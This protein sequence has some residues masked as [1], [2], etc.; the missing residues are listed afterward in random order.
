MQDRYVGD[1][2]DFAK[3]GLLRRLIHTAELRLGVVWC[4][5]PDESHN[6]DGRHVAYLNRPELEAADPPLFSELAKIVSS[7]RR[8]VRKIETSSILPRGTICHRASVARPLD[9]SRALGKAARL[10]QRARWLAGAARAVKSCDI[11]FFDPDNGFET[12]SV[13]KDSPRAG[14]YIF[15]D[16][17]K[18]FWR[19]GHS[20]VVYHHLNRTASV[21]TQTQSLRRLILNHFPD[22]ALVRAVLFRRGSCRQFWIIGNSQHAS[23]LENGIAEMLNSGWRDLFEI[24]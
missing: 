11:V 21:A 17:L 5:F 6:N 22:A 23:I 16:E 18:S 13:T 1:V 10:Q 24:T 20:L 7:G 2:G 9:V 19:S 14:K 3:Y 4:F 15:I 8:S 12:P